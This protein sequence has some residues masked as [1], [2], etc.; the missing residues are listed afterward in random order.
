MSD[1]YLLD[2]AW[3]HW[4]MIL[5]AYKLYEE[6]KPVVLFDIQEQRI[7]LY[8]YCEPT[9]HRS[10]LKGSSPPQHYPHECQPEPPL[11]TP[12]GGGS[13][14]PCPSGTWLASDDRGRQSASATPIFPAFCEVS[15][16]ATGTRSR[17]R[18]AE[19]TQPTTASTS[20]TGVTSA[21]NRSDAPAV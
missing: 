3:E 15:R 12:V 6:H 11:S 17:L 19:E 21:T 20:P 10:V 2:A 1:D 8:P 14:P 4:D 5:S 7:Y 13:S 9:T 16:M 18:P